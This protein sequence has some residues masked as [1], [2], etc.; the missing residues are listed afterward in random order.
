[1]AQSSQPL[2]GVT[3]MWQMDE[4]QLFQLDRQYAANGSPDGSMK[5]VGDS[6]HHQWEQQMI[7]ANGGKLPELPMLPPPAKV[8]QSRTKVTQLP[9]LPR[10]A[11]VPPLRTNGPQ[12]QKKVPQSR[13]KVKQSQKKVSQS[14]KKVPQSRAKVQQAR[15]QLPQ[16]RSHVP[17]SRKRV[18]P[19]RIIKVSQRTNVVA[20]AYMCNVWK[21]CVK[22]LLKH[23]TNTR[24]HLRLKHHQLFRMISCTVLL[25]GVEAEV[26][27]FTGGNGI[28]TL[29]CDNRNLYGGSIQ[30][31]G[32][33]HQAH[34]WSMNPG[35]YLAKCTDIV[36]IQD[37][38]EADQG[39]QTPSISISQIRWLGT[40]SEFIDYT[41][42]SKK[43]LGKAKYDR[44]M[45]M[46]CSDSDSEDWIQHNAAIAGHGKNSQHK[47]VRRDGSA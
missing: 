26:N 25:H 7:V 6:S 23:Y 47:P 13:T 24:H 28:V 43:K 20:I 33:F 16:S 34:D 2:T 12:S 37:L 30:V 19:P 3:A 40:T 8:P 10:P 17:Q 39:P 31:D 42:R 15:K 11:A 9:L 5:I 46:L 36:E 41:T 1:M 35:V 14:R 44:L 4:N 29:P 27:W 21:G 18:Q 45:E 38:D 22:L 32:I